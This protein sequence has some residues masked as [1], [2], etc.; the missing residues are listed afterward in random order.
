MLRLRNRLLPTVRAALPLPAAASLHRLLLLPLSTATASSAPFDAEDYLVTACGLT[1]AQALKSSRRLAHVKSP[2]NADAVLAFFADIGLARADIAAAIARDPNVLCSKVDQTLLPRIRMLRDAGLAIPQISSLI[3]TVPL[4][5]KNP[6]MIARLE[7]YLSFLGSFEKAHIA[8]RRSNRILSRDVE[9]VVKPNIGLLKRCGLTDQDIL[10]I[11]L[12]QPYV[13]L[14]QPERIKETLV[15]ADQLGVPRDSALFKC[16]LATAYNVGPERIASRFDFLKKALGCSEAEVGIA[17][18]KDPNILNFA[19]DKLSR[20]VEFLKMKVGLKAEYI[21]HRPALL[22]YSLTK[23]LKPRHYVLKVLQSRGLVKKDMDFYNVVCLTEKRFANKFLDPYKEDIP[24]LAAAYEEQGKLSSD[25]AMLRLRNHLLP[26]IR[27]ASSLPAAAFLHRLLLLPLPLST[28][29]ASSAPFDAEDYLVTAC[30]LTPAQAL[31]SSRHLA[32]VKSPSNADAVLAFFVDIGLSR[33][34][35]AAA[36]ARDPNV[37]CSKVDQTLLPRIRMLR[38]AG[39][40][41]PQISSLISTVPVILRNP[42]MISR[43]EFYLS[44]LGSFEKVHLAIRRSNRYLLNR[45]VERAVKPNIALLKQCG[46]TDQDILQIFLLQPYVVLQQPERV[47]ETL[48]CA[49]QLGVPRDSALFKRALATAYNVGPERIAS[50]LDFLKKALG[51]SEAE[52]GIAV[53]KS[54]NILNFAEDKMSR[55]VEFLKM[56]VGLKA[57][58]IVHRPAVLHYSLTRRLKPRHYVLKVLQSRGL[59][60]KDIDFYN[61]VCLTEKRFANKTFLDLRLLLKSKLLLKPSHDRLKWRYSICLKV[62]SAAST[63]PFSTYPDKSA[64]HET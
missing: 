12:L 17:V 26:T 10:Q 7:F 13:V 39:L 55:T 38:D 57:E 11:F 3:S 20:T 59:V 5:L 40:A 28:A 58:Y 2:S 63:S 62:S 43:L 46:L 44:F 25:P 33:A 6:L 61:V 23:R 41:T 19:E 47:K 21:V 31:K 9:R 53:C 8:L 14:Q 22:Q 18:R 27:A 37:L 48:V 36:I 32:H 15:C 52:V 30:G 64:S 4:I 35:I 49:D 42:V 34:D 60:K 50:R 45:D 51:C 54:P 24:G 16:A 29:T 56:K 1:P